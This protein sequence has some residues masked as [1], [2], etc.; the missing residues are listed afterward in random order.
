MITNG[1]IYSNNSFNPNNGTHSDWYIQLMSRSLSNLVFCLCYASWRLQT[2]SL[3]FESSC[4]FHIK[5]L[6]T[7]R[8]ICMAMYTYAC[9][10][11]NECRL[12]IY[13]TKIP[14]RSAAASISWPMFTTY[15]SSL[16]FH[17]MT[18]VWLVVIAQNTSKHYSA[19][20][21]HSIQSRRSSAI[22]YSYTNRTSSILCCF[23]SNDLTLGFP[24]LESAQSVRCLIFCLYL[25]CT[26]YNILFDCQATLLVYVSTDIYQYEHSCFNFFFWFFTT[27]QLIQNV[28]ITRVPTNILNDHSFRDSV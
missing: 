3:S 20:S 12:Q 18:V 23:C 17:R 10:S 21:L 8:S 13:Y 22:T 6:G 24:P 28:W 19:N 15:Q 16:R 2:F 7:K 27:F 1:I 14:T 26:G 9:Q 5:V 25:S 4:Q 11:S